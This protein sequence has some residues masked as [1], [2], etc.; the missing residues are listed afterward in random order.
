M[1]KT[2]LFGIVLGVIA[3][4]TAVYFVPV[5]DQAREN[6]V[7]T[8]MPNGG[9]SE[10]YHINIPM[11]RIAVGAAEQSAPLPPGME[12]PE[13]FASSSAELYKLR[14][15]HDSVIGVASRVV[16]DNGEDG[17][18]I[19][20][21]LHFPARGS[22]FVSMQPRIEEGQQRS[23]S[24]LSGT[25]EFGS[26]SGRVTEAYVPLQSD[27]ELRRGRIELVSSYRSSPGSEL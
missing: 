12:W 17:S 20:W 26:L 13:A 7:I 14:N 1:F 23:G 6:S 25:R 8:V 27:D 3:A 5:V 21:V 24:I 22:L 19:E 4:F 15:I 16:V 10:S 9:N 11:D 18:A 2:Y